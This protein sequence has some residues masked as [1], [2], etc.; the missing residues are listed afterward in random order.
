MLLNGK[1]LFEMTHEMTANV[2]DLGPLLEYE[3]NA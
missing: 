1:R 3:D 2:V